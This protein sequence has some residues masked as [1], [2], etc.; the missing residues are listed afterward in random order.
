M[1]NRNIR[2]SLHPM[3]FIDGRHPS[4]GWILLNLDGVSE[5]NLKAA[6]SGFVL[7]GP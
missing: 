7:R 3:F 2:Q 6:G 1:M 5:T 4:D